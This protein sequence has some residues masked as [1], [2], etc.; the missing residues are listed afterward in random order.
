[1]E[2]LDR[3]VK[4]DRKPEPGRYS[5]NSPVVVGLKVV[6]D[7]A[8]GLPTTERDDV[9]L[10]DPRSLVLTAIPVRVCGSEVSAAPVRG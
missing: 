2:S 5:T 7:L 9:R 6:V 8:P 1:L 4:M 3:G 10:V